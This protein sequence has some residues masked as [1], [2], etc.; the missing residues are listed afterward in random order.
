MPVPP[1]TIEMHRSLAA[2]A[3]WITASEPRPFGA[4]QSPGS[5]LVASAFI[6]AM[7]SP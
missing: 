1:F 3:V 4:R 5:A 6:C 7:N 2:R